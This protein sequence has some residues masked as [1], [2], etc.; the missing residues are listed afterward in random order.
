MF[1]E[2][3]AMAA[4]EGLELEIEPLTSSEREGWTKANISC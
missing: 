1:Q 4:T 3:G 2:E